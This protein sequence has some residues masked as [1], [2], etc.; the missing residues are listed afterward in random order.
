MKFKLAPVRFDIRN[1]SPGFFASL[2]ATL[3]LKGR[4]ERLPPPL[5]GRVGVGGQFIRAVATSIALMLLSKPGLAASVIV[6]VGNVRVA[7]G[8]VRASLCADEASYKADE[9]PRDAIARAHKGSTDLR[10]DNV[11]PGTYA[12]QLFHDKNGNG[13]MDFNFLGIPR[14]GFGFSNN[15]K[16]GFSAPKFAKVAFAVG[17]AD[18]HL[19]IDLLHY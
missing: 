1:P 13:K 17:D 8:D 11:P 3:S 7:S 6:T 2:E 15:A 5:R 19:N 18:V 9:C 14:E 12:I 16:P 10:F 4:G